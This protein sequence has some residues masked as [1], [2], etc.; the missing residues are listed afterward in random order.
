MSIHTIFI[1]LMVPPLNQTPLF[2]CMY[3]NV[4][5][6]LTLCIP[7]LQTS[8]QPKKICQMYIICLLHRHF[9]KSYSGK[10]RERARDE[11]IARRT[12]TTKCHLLV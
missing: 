12:A 8:Q 11:K 5:T 9:C 4:F 6:I 3:N 7:S 10:E 2:K 1:S